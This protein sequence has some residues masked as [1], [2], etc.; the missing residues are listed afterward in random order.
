MIS[1]VENKIEVGNRACGAEGWGTGFSVP[2]EDWGR[3]YY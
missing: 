2:Q 1:V 3:P